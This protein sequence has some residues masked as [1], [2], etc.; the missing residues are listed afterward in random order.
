MKMA[1]AWRNESASC[2]GKINGGNEKQAGCGSIYGSG[3]NGKAAWHGVAK[4]FCSA[5]ACLRNG[6]I[7][8]YKRGK[9]ADIK[10]TAT[11]LTCRRKTR[12]EGISIS[13]LYIM[14]HGGIIIMVLNFLFCIIK[15]GSPWRLAGVASAKRVAKSRSI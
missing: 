8:A 5:A 15:R 2:G 10:K 13:S 14:N 9:Y 11:V 12:N 6:G 3:V 4:I 1:A 7:M